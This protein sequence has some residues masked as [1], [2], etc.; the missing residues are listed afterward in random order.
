MWFL[1]AVGLFVF[2][3]LFVPRFNTDTSPVTIG[4]IGSLTSDT[5]DKARYA[6]SAVELAVDEINELGGVDGRLLEVVYKDGGCDSTMAH[7]AARDLIENHNVVAIIGGLCSHETLGFTDFAESSK[8][9]VLSFCS[10]APEISHAGDYVFRINPSSV[11]HGHFDAGYVRK[12]L[13]KQRA[14]ILYVDAPWGIGLMNSF[15]EAFA[16][17]GGEIIA[18]ESHLLTDTDLR[19]Q[20][21][22]M[23]SSDPDLIYFL[24]YADT[25]VIGLNQMQELGLDVP[26]LGGSTWD[27]QS[28]WEVA[29]SLDAEILYSISF[30][31]LNSEFR[32]S[33]RDRFGITDIL[34]CVPHAYD[35]VNILAQVIDRV[36][37]NSES[38]KNELYRTVYNSGISSN[39]IRF[40]ENGDVLDATYLIKR[41]VGGQAEEVEY[42]RTDQHG[43]VL[44]DI[45]G[46]VI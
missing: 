39:Q 4:F 31:P 22:N 23:Q 11:R 15:S 42:Y 17:G 12:V 45:Q 38:I 41:A 10:T 46:A 30:S 27:N 13:D 18:R 24:S 8:T 36:G 16:R 35:W 44:R 40:D 26:V 20:I 6:K 25:S 1:V 5:S 3:Y 21:V 28:V 14:A 33:M 9:P 2:L 37:T 7:E 29:G 43:E 19:E 32:N 34:E